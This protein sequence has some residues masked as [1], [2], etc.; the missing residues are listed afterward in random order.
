MELESKWLGLISRHN[1]HSLPTSVSDI[2]SFQ[3]AAETSGAVTSQQLPPT[4]VFRLIS[5][6]WAVADL[7]ILVT[8]SYDVPTNTFIYDFAVVVIIK[9][10]IT[11]SMLE[12][13]D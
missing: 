9:D 4:Y 13:V 11:T 6:N 10:P 2:I 12:Y 5:Y 8:H 7:V 3:T 1:N